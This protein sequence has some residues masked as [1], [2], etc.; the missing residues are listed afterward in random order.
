MASQNLKYTQYL[1][2]LTI[3]TTAATLIQAT[4]LSDR[5]YLNSFLEVSLLLLTK[6]ILPLPSQSLF[7][8]QQLEWPFLKDNSDHVI[9]FL[10]TPNGSPFPSES[11]YV[12]ALLKV[13]KALLDISG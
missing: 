5:D 3:S 6:G 9:P 10:K 11:I 12:K 2:F 4:T 1:P 7:S 13:Y 8:I